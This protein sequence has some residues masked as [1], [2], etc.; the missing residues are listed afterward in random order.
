MKRFVP[1]V[2]SVLTLAGVGLAADRELLD[3]IRADRPSLVNKLLADG[4]SINSHDETGATALMYAAV[5]SS[6]DVMRLLLTRGADVNA[7]NATGATALMWAAGDVAKVRLLLEH[8]AA[9]NAKAVDGATALLVAAR[10]GNTDAARAL[11][12][13]GADVKAVPTDAWQRA[14]YLREDG[15]EM[16]RLL[17]G[18][19]AELG[20]QAQL[21]SVLASGLPL[22]S[23]AA[24]KRIAAGGGEFNRELQLVV[25]KLAPIHLVAYHGD[26]DLLRSLIER[27]ASVNARTSQG[28]T[29][30]M[31]AAAS[32]R[33]SPE[34]VRL[35]LA[36]GADLAARDEAGRN[37]LDWALTQG[38]TPMAAML[39]K[40]GATETPPSPAPPRVAGP[41][42]TPDAIERAVA[43]LQPA[44]PTFNN[45]TKCISCHNQS[46]P[47][48]AV[49]LAAARGV[50]VDRTLAAHPTEAT[51][52]SWKPTRDA[53]LVGRQSIGG[54]VA[55][56][57]YGLVGLA[58]DKVEPNLTTDAVAIA[59]AALQQRDG[60]WNIDDIRPPLI[61]QSPVSFTAL[62]IRGL[63]VYA[64]PGRR[65]EMT[66]RLS[67]ASAYLRGAVA[68]STQD[69]AFK[70][71]GLVWSGVQADEISRQA[72]RL[73][74]LQRS[75]GG[76]AQLPTL[77]SD[78]YGTGQALFAL[79]LAGVPVQGDAYRRGTAF[80][81]RT[82]LEDGTWFLRSRAFGFQAY[83]ETG[84]PHGR[85][86]FI[87]SAATAWAVMALAQSLPVRR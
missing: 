86:Q 51:L 17:E 4:E 77:F 25:L 85:D 58:E 63:S 21:T 8:G 20:S 11:L 40:A 57:T 42:A 53:L 81:L 80:L 44:G 56:V 59:L 3:A 7:A 5:Y 39:R 19:G 74:A 68:A 24:A 46:L 37:V 72:A 54:F 2:L 84:F 47:S 36:R 13:A 75:D 14:V 22:T 28:A 48:I 35:L 87:S 15:D 67:R 79:Q 10:H 43:Q 33:P 23:F 34:T 73:L 26:V 83:F 65:D 12:A 60:S 32:P 38:E 61:D 31:L 50:T 29:P 18:A 41:R 49:S 71:M 16:R 70:L 62:T 82:Q 6:P 78:A 30:V 64:P 27:G 69:E 55:N 1:L 9:A 45:R 76:W 52:T 66:V